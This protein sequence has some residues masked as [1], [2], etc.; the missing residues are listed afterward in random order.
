I[1][2]LSVLFFFSP[3]ILSTAFSDDDFRKELE[4]LNKRV[5]ELEQRLAEKEKVEVRVPEGISGE[6]DSLKEAIG[7]L[8]FSLGIT[9]IVQG[10]IN[11]D[12][13][14]RAVLGDGRDVFD[15]SYSVDLEIHAPVGENGD[16]WVYFEG[17]E[18]DNVTDELGVLG[19]INA[20]ALGGNSNP[21]ISTWGYE[22]SFNDDLAILTIGKLD[23]VAYF[24]TNNVA[25]DE[26]A[27]FL[28][29]FFINN[30]A[31]EFPDYTP[32]VRLTLNPT[33]MLEINLGWLEND[34]DFE[35]LFDDSFGIAELNFKPGFLGLEGNYRF[36]G[37]VNGSD[38]EEW[39]DPTADEKGEGFGLSFDQELT[40]ALTAFCRFG[41][42]DED[43][44][45]AEYY[46]T[47]G[48]AIS[49]CMWGREEDVLAF[50][51]GQAILGDEYGDTLVDDGDESH[52]ECYY[53]YKLNDHF[54]ISPMIHVVTNPGGDDDADTVVIPGFR[55]QMDF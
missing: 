45:E 13:N 49:G 20:D 5:Q 15:G 4:T 37:W 35:D 18:G 46:W 10:T 23:P 22:H 26:T 7:N 42:Q 30:N 9:G 25:N 47:L 44:Y 29:D 16:L 36:Y 21:Q 11:N 38:H 43:V 55:T 32:G 19:G 52:F 34:A 12:H 33:E 53:S 54:T 51:F 2:W 27:D 41:F 8:Q 40:D 39:D 1:F 3:F 24:D 17:G 48:A 14:A 6:V 28:S 31:V 50:A